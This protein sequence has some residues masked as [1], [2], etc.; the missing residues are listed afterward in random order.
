[1]RSLANS[2]AAVKRPTS[3]STSAGAM[4]TC[5]TFGTSQ[6]MTNAGPDTMPGE[7]GIPSRTRLTPLLLAEAAFDQQRKRVDG[8]LRVVAR[9]AN[10]N[11]AAALRCQHHHTH[12]ALGIHLQ[13]ILADPDLALELMRRL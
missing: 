1:M 8:G 13:I 6:C 11:L 9:G 7:A 2:R 12:D 5:G 4:T 3:F 10:R